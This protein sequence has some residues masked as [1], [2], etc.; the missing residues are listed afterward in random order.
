MGEDSRLDRYQ[1]ET[2]DLEIFRI[3][4]LWLKK[5]LSEA[6]FIYDLASL[7]EK[8]FLGSERLFE[9]S[10][11][12]V[13][14]DLSGL[15]VRLTERDRL[16]MRKRLRLPVDMMDRGI[17]RRSRVRSNGSG[18]DASDTT[19]LASGDHILPFFF[20]RRSPFHSFAF[21][22]SIILKH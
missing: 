1:R 22:L 8:I 20:A 16:I 14:P 7:F 12:S 18:Y 3:R 6:F 15:V 2:V 19:Y 13:D 17:F 5:P 21:F 10:S 4:I 11:R 9:F